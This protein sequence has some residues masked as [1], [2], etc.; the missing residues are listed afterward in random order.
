[1]LGETLFGGGLYG[2]DFLG[3]EDDN[4]AQGDDL[5]CD[6]AAISGTDLLPP[7]C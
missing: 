2:G 3:E 7:Q 5:T 6:E 1:M 4:Y